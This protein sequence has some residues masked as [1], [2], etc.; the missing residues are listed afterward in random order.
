MTRKSPAYSFGEKIAISVLQTHDTHKPELAMAKVLHDSTVNRQEAAAIA[1]AM[2][3]VAPH[4]ALDNTRVDLYGTQVK[5]LQQRMTENPRSAPHQRF[6]AKYDKVEGLPDKTQMLPDA[7][8]PDADTVWLPSGNPGIMMHEL[9]HSI[10]FN[11]YPNDT[12]RMVG[13]G[14]YRNLAPTIWKEHAAWD[15]GKQYFLEGAAH[16]K[17]PPELVVKTLRDATRAKYTGLGSYWG[18]GLGTLLGGGLGA[19]GTYALVRNGYAGRGVGL[20]FALGLGLGGAGGAMTGAALGSSYADDKYHDSPEAQEK[21][22]TEY[23]GAYGKKHKMSPEEARKAI[24]NLAE[25]LYAK[26]QKK[27]KKV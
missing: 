26:K 10:D 21:Y 17:L 20:P 9:G 24:Q 5:D 11:G 6:M 13:A 7:Y 18:G 27:K 1:N 8:H 12:L 4:G 3:A 15:K 22:L 2:A 19:L 23:A 25:K 16:T 14:L